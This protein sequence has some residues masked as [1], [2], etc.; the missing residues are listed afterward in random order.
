MFCPMIILG[1]EWER[2]PEEILRLTQ[3]GIS[4]MMHDLDVSRDVDMSFLIWEVSVIVNDIKPAQTI[5]DEMASL[6]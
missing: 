1:S 5:V 3:Q 2:R 4:P 6:C